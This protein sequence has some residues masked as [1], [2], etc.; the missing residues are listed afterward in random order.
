[1]HIWRVCS[2]A[3]YAVNEI[4]VRNDRPH[5]RHP[6]YIRLSKPVTPPA[7]A[8]PSS[9]NWY[10]NAVDSASSD[11]EDAA[12]YGYEGLETPKEEEPF[13]WGLLYPQLQT[14]DSTSGSQHT[15]AG[16]SVASE[17]D[18]TTTAVPAASTLTSSTLASS[19]SVS[20]IPTSTATG[21]TLG[22][23]LKNSF[24]NLANKTTKHSPPEPV[25]SWEDSIFHGF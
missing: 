10:S 9:G 12:L 11:A 5:T 13:D 3:K 16:P 17:E 19:T 14:H 7:P 20:S 15:A 25:D 21:P 1:M 18:T 24:P 8:V 6:L 4:R 23:L 22:D 2:A